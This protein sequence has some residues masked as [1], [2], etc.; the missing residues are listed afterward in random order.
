MTTESFTLYIRQPE[1]GIT[2]RNLEYWE[3]KIYY[4]VH[5]DLCDLSNW[6]FYGISD[7][8]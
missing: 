2:L 3:Y 8:K 7:L 5:G 6:W 1:N 4:M